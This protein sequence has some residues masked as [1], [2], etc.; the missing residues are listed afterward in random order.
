MNDKIRLIVANN[1]LC[2]VCESI[3]CRTLD[4][5][6][7]CGNEDCSQC[8]KIYEVVSPPQYVEAQGQG[9]LANTL[10]ALWQNG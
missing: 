8:G 5:G 1:F 9:K 2:P 7:Y 10:K 4:E 6:F 3:M